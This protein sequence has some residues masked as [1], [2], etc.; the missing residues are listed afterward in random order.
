MIDNSWGYHMQQFGLSLCLLS[1]A[2]VAMAPA[3]AAEKVTYAVATSNISV[4]HAAQ[5]SIPLA[6]GYWKD[7]GLDVDVVGLSGATA[8]IQQVA[9]GQVDFATVGGDALLIARAKGL[10]VKAVYVYAR[11]SIY[12]IV[13]PESS[14]VKTL[15][16]LKDKTL[17]VP[18][19]SAGSVPYAR[20]ALASAGIDPQTNVKWLSIGIGGQAANAFRQNVVD[21]W[22][23]W[24]TVIASLE[25]NGFKLRYIDPPWLDEILGNVIV[26][27]EETIAKNPNLVIKVARGIAKSSVFGLANPDAAL[28]NH[29][30]MYPETKPSVMNDETFREGRHIFNSRFDLTKREPGVKWGENVPAVWKRM[31][32]ISIQEGLIPKNFNV[33]AAYTNQFISEINNFDQ[34]K[35]EEAAKS[36]NW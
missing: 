17:G 15:A 10:K 20:A 11:R 4:G 23:A 36:S 12:R 31:A 5:S 25:N 33:E 19:M 24:D 7:E 2:L 3:E 1:M 35:I 18:D 32:D 16:D 29:W 27:R 14:T 34:G 21:G 28:R 13:V 8:G 9:S 6:Q 22:A 26:A 30:K